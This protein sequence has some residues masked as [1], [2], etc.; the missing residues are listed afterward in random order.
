MKGA[1]ILLA[2]C[3][4]V[5]LIFGSR[6]ADERSEIV[7]ERKEIDTRWAQLDA[8]MKERADRVSTLLES[9]KGRASQTEEPIM[10]EATSAREAF[11]DARTKQ[12]K[13]NANQRLSKAAAQLLRIKSD[14]NLLSVQDELAREENQIAVDR[15]DYNDAITRY[16][17]NIELFPKN[18]AAG[19]F[20]FHRDDEYFK[21]AEH[22]SS[23]D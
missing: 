3:I 10:A 14:E 6:L 22:H 7:A 11:S 16:N 21:T 9:L 20:G 18:V 2:A 8:D 5:V 19:I 15:R 12:D 1:F 17:S 4:A 23:S 13:M